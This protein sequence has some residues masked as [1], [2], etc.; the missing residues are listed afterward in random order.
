MKLELHLFYIVAI[1]GGGWPISRFDRCVPV[2]HWLGGPQSRFGY[3]GAKKIPA[4]AV[5]PEVTIPHSP[6]YRI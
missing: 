6:H 5:H 4:P 2:T 1:N 3:C